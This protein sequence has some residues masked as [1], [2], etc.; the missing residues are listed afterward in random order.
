[1]TQTT[2]VHAGAV[3]P[4]YRE[5]WPWI[6]IAFPAA[7]VFMGIA[8]VIL[9]IES[10]DGLVTGDYYRQG[11]AINR[12]LARETKARTLGIRA[13][14]TVDPSR[15]LLR[16]E[17]AGPVPA[18]RIV[19]VSFVHPTRAG[20]DQKVL[21]LPDGRGGWTGRLTLPGAVEKWHVVVEEPESGWRLAGIWY[22]DD[23][24]FTLGEPR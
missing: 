3:R 9:A 13:F 16:A 4:W 23:A 14:M 18:K 7:S 1:M 21:L 2:A 6:L 12:V 15:G 20:F 8:T 11:L 5:P 22:T 10:Q 17:F 19:H 24:E